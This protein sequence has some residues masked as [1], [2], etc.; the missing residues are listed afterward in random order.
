MLLWKSGAHLHISICKIVDL[1]FFQ[2]LN[3]WRTPFNPRVDHFHSNCRA[4]VNGANRFKFTR[5]WPSDRCADSP[6]PTANVIISRQVAAIFTLNWPQECRAVKI[7]KNYLKDFTLIRDETS[8]MLMIIRQFPWAV[9]LIHFWPRPLTDAFD[10]STHTHTQR[11][12]FTEKMFLS[13][14]SQVCRWF[15]CHNGRPLLFQTT[16]TVNSA[17]R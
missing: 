6:R 12:C 9:Q 1:L 7:F 4:F 14:G 8:A 15:Q 10:D 13:R 17:P 3:V 2:C 16:A 5:K 11:W